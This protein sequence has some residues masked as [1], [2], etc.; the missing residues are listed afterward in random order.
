MQNVARNHELREI[1]LAQIG[2]NVVE[3]DHPQEPT[4]GVDNIEVVHPD[5]EKDPGNFGEPRRLSHHR[6]F[7]PHEIG[8]ARLMRKRSDRLG[9]GRLRLQR[10]AVE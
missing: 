6:R 2:L 9:R 7:H 8:H 4:L 10:F 3:R 5:T 1:G